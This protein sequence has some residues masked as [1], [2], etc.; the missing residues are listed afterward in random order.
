MHIIFIIIFIS[1]LTPAF[2]SEY[3]VLKIPVA[4]DGLYR[5]TQADLSDSGI[6]NDAASIDPSTFQIFYL[7]KEI[8]IKT[9]TD[10]EGY[11]VEFFAQGIDNQFTGTN[12]YWLEWGDLQGRRI[13]AIDGKLTGSGEK[14]DYFDETL[15][16]EEN[17]TL[18]EKTPNAP[19][20]DYC[21][22]EKIEYTGSA[23]R[24]YYVTVNSPVQGKTAVIRIIYQGRSSV[25]RHTAV[26]LNGTQIGEDSWSN[27]AAHIQ[28]IIISSDILN[29]GI[30]T[31]TIEFSGTVLDV[32]YLNRIEITYPRKSE[33]VNNSLVSDIEGEGRIQMEI[34]DFTKSDIRIYDITEPE[35][36]KEIQNI[37]VISDENR[38]KAVFE[39]NI[40]GKKRYYALTSNR[41]KKPSGISVYKSADLKNNEN[42]ADYILITS[43]ELL[44]SLEPLCQ[45]RENQGLRVKKVCTEDIF[46][47]FGFGLFNPRSLKD[48][49]K[50]AYEN[51]KSPA[52][53]YV[54]L[55]GDANTDYRD[56]LGSGKADKLPTHLSV[57]SLGL[58]PDDNWY[59]YGNDLL[60]YMMIG[61]I[62]GSSP[63]MISRTVNKIIEYENSREYPESVLLAAYNGAEFENVS[64]SLIPFIPS[65]FTVNKVYGSSDS[66][67]KI[68]S[69]INTGELITN[70]VGHG[71]V[72][73]WGA[74]FDAS[75][76]ASLNN[77]KKLTFVIS[78]SCLNGYFSQ[79]FKY[80]ISEEFLMADDKGAVAVFSPSG[81]GQTWELDILNKE[82]FSDIFEKQNSVIGK[83][84]EQAK[85]SAYKKG[86]SNEI[87]KM[88]NL[89]GDPATR[90]KI[91]FPGDTDGNGEPG[92]EDVIIVL[93]IL[94]GFKE[95]V[96]IKSDVNKNGK[97]DFAEAIYLLQ[98]ISIADAI[99]PGYAVEQMGIYP[100]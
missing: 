81:L 45:H 11:A 73:N 5:I 16:I 60:P 1:F 76:I 66:V 19:E 63:E 23:S 77:N 67:N 10:K 98:R 8:A 55:A 80:S 35:N 64:E 26:K 34:S 87:L 41:I 90:L 13:N 56:Y 49:L 31:V 59:V 6:T 91:I 88:F 72:T 33:S 51:W 58:T 97:I 43:K 44:S 3:S 32:L 36:V 48:F 29:D 94:A 89:L 54:L 12:V 85:I 69:G 78:M 68:I 40:S 62:T 24:E 86:V 4:Q 15:Y 92:L 25:N 7:G 47:E 79:P 100:R 42:Q 9:V 75:N 18:W 38:Y 2:A 21:F 95:P 96:N 50:Y 53:V 37:S 20:Q 46:N 70:Y 14:T 82:I 39:D 28:E 30:N 17:H 57:T 52:P 61:R 74:M 27:D 93:K 99:H 22:W 71:N 83:I 65:E 84:V